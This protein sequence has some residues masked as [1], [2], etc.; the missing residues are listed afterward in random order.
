MRPL[1][2]DLAVIIAA[3]AQA[4][5][6]R[7]LAAC[8]GPTATPGRDGQPPDRLGLEL[9][10]LLAEPLGERRACSRGRRT[11]MIIANSSPPTR[12]TTSV[13]AHGRAEDVRDLVAGAWSPIAVPVDVVDLLEVVE[14]EHHEGDRVVLGRRTHEL[15]AEP[16]VEGAVVVEAGQR[17]GRGLVLEAGADVGVVDR[18]RGGVAE[19]GREQELL[20]R[21][22]LVLADAVDV[23]RPLEM[24]ARDQRAPR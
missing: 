2:R 17:V 23:E 6:S 12:Q 18:E 3:S 14:V 8:S 10:E 16:V 11:G 5:S 4:T 19:A 20:V 15:L 22:L 1:P 7:G 9:P 21:E 13:V 24:P